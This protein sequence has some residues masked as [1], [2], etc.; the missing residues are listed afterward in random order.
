MVVNGNP[1]GD[2]RKSQR[3]K[4]IAGVSSFK[5]VFAA[6][7]ELMLGVNPD[8][9]LGG[10]PSP[11]QVTSAGGRFTAIFAAYS[12]SIDQVMDFSPPAKLSRNLP[13]RHLAS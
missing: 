3:I 6:H 1:G 5:R 11:S 10:S 12:A 8:N 9:P 7:F 4:L 2:V 13:R